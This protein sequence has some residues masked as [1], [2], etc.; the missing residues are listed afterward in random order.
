MW[1]DE[2]LSLSKEVTEYSLDAFEDGVA[3]V[4]H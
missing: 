2:I 1:D 3:E 4:L